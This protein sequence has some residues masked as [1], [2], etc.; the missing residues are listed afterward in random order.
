MRGG[1]VYVSGFAT[2][3]EVRSV[4]L[5]GSR[6]RKRAENA[7]K[8]LSTLGVRQWIYFSGTVSPRFPWDEA[9]MRRVVVSTSTV[10]TRT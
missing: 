6:A 8:Y 2:T 1:L 7:A 9:R 5:V 4:W 3:T 10:S